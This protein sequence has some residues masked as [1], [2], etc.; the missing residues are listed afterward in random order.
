LAPGEMTVLR[1]SVVS[2]EALA[3]VAAEWQLGSALRL[4]R[5][6]AHSGGRDRPS[7]LS[8]A[9]EAVVGAVYLDAGFAAAAALI[10]SALSERLREL[11]EGQAEVS[12]ET[13]PKSLLQELAQAQGLNPVYEVVG[14]TGPDH[15]PHWIVQV[16][17]QG[18]SSEGGG[19]SRRVA[20]KDAARR[21]LEV[22]QWQRRE[23]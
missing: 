23:G 14:R 11:A 22:L 6:E 4:G 1:A 7:N 8:R 18:V 20:E 9:F 17:V 13:D 10:D 5:G 12:L 15:A 16:Q 19:P 21:L 2:G 3:A